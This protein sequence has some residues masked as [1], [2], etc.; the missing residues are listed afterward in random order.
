MLPVTQ[1]S[2]VSQMY[3]TAPTRRETQELLR[4]LRSEYRVNDVSA[5][6]MLQRAGT[7]RSVRVRDGSRG[8]V[9]RVLAAFA[10]AFAAGNASP[11]GA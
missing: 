7:P 5:R 9:H 6:A 11:G 4:C 3:T 2:L 1:T 8:W 10:E